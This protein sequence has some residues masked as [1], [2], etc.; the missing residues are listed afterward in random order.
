M[1]SRQRRAQETIELARIES[2]CTRTVRVPLDTATAFATRRVLARD[3]SLVRVETNAG[4]A[5]IGFCYGGSSGGA[6]VSHAVREL[7]G[8]LLIGQESHAVERL[9]EQM[10]REALLHGRAGAVHRAVSILDIALWDGNA[11][12]AGLP[13]Y[14]YLGAYRTGSVPAYAS[15]GYYLEGKGPQGLAEELA[16][17]VALGFRAVKMKVGLLG[18]RDEE[19]RTALPGRQSVLMYC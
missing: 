11:R 12:A 4:V 9:W 19:A 8:P 7:L 17:Y 15:G 2:V 5:G 14:K 18:E 13:L 6:L 1:L 10:Y 16:S 3:Y